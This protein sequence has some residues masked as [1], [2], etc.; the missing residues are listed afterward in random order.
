VTLIGATQLTK[1]T[2]AIIVRTYVFDVLF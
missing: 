2:L 1:S